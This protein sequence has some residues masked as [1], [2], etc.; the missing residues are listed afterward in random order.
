MSGKNL[1]SDLWFGSLFLSRYPFKM[2]WRKFSA[3]R[4]QCCLHNIFHFVPG[5]EVHELLFAAFCLSQKSLWS[6]PGSDWLLSVGRSRSLWSMRRYDWLFLCVAEE[7]YD[8]C[9]AL[10]DHFLFGAGKACDQ[11]RARI[12]HVSRHATR[13]Q[14]KGGHRPATWCQR[15]FMSRCLIHT[16]ILNSCLFLSGAG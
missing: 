4:Q 13:C 6:V 3:N 15:Y 2:I 11:C 12:R 5:T 7:A 8:Q 1:A 16:S 9:R 10:I 14:E